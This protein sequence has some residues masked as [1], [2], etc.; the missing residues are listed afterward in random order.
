MKIEEQ[1]CTLEQAKKLKTLGVNQDAYFSWFGD[2]QQRLMDNGKEGMAISNWLFVSSTEPCNNQEADWRSDVCLKPI[3]AAFTTAELGQLLSIVRYESFGFPMMFTSYCHSSDV[4]VGYLGKWS[5]AF[6]NPK[7]FN[8]PG[9]KSDNEA[10]AR[11]EILIWL[12]ENG[13]VK[14]DNI[15]NGV[16]PEGSL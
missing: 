11:A 1:V 13:H 8:N 14:A 5:C 15:N 10:E 4:S 3:A 6:R 12:L 16:C 9:I 2:E 7:Q